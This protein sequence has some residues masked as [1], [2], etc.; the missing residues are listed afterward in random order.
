MLFNRGLGGGLPGTRCAPRCRNLPP[1]DSYVQIG[2]YSL[3]RTDSYIP[4]RTYRRVRTESHIQVYAYR[5][6]RSIFTAV[7]FIMISCRSCCQKCKLF[8]QSWVGGLPGTRCEPRCRNSP[9]SG[10][11]VQIRTYSLIRTDSYIPI[12]TYRLVRTD[13]Y[14]Q[15]PTYLFL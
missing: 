14:L 2:T 15:I 3:I 8:I 4:T 6:V 7:K 12:R 1:P 9:P 5:F 13:P 10:S 11:Y